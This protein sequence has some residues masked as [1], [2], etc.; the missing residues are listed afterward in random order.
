MAPR[1]GQALPWIV[2]YGDQVVGQITIGPIVWSSLRSGQVGAWIDEPFARQRITGTAMA[3]AVDYCFQVAGLHRLE[4]LI[5]PENVPSRRGVEK[6]GWRE[7]GV[8]S[9]RVGR[10]RRSCLARSTWPRLGS[11][12]QRNAAGLSGPP[13]LVV[14]ARQGDTFTRCKFEVGAVVRRQAVASADGR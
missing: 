8:K 6:Y 5:R 9:G 14:T 11:S 12:E 7:E 1:L 13:Q 3:M 2:T 4:A 10:L